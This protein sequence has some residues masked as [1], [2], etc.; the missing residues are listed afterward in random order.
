VAEELRVLRDALDE[1][2]PAKRVDH[3]LVIATWN[4]RAFGDVTEKWETGEDDSPKRNLADL[5]A[6][7]DILSRFDVVAIQETRS[8]L[9]ALRHV[10]KVLGPDW[11]FILSDTTRGR[12][13][14]DERLAFVFDLR[15]VRPSGLACE[16]VVPQEELDAERI[17]EGALREQ[18]ART[19][20]AVSFMASGSTF[21]LV[22]LHVLYGKKAEER[23]R[24]L[25]HIA[26]WLGRWAGQVG[27][28]G[29]NLIALGDFN[30]DRKDDPNYQ[31]FVSQGLRPPPELD[32]LPRTTSDLPG[33]ISFYDQIAWFWG[34]GKPELT[35][36]YTKRAGIFRWTEHYLQEL[37]GVGKTWRVSD[38]YPL[39]AEFSTRGP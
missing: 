18:F 3:N 33:E 37:D 38:H 22:T 5:R 19:P 8:N 31:A 27:Q 17:S 26:E 35:L 34:D 10:L 39:W 28:Y 30:I 7:A 32:D 21:T 29:H 4:I 12:A 15:R 23:V 14:N 2:V 20:Y 16:L 9:K 6:I 25:G 36:R 13:G 24:E 11:G 1:A